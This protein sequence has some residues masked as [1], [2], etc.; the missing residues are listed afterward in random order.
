MGVLDCTVSTDHSRT[1]SPLTQLFLAASRSLRRQA[2][3]H[4]ASPSSPMSMPTCSS[5]IPAVAVALPRPSPEEMG[6]E[7]SIGFSAMVNTW[8]SL[9]FVVIRCY[10][11]LL[12]FRRMSGSPG[13]LSL[14]SLGMRAMVTMA[15]AVRWLQRFGPSMWEGRNASLFAGVWLGLGFPS[16]T[17]SKL[18]AAPYSS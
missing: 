4:T 15:V 2:A 9:V 3:N 16:T 7:I 5:F 14:V 10:P 12:E 18:S 8:V 6:V 13:S 11:Q 1:L 17:S